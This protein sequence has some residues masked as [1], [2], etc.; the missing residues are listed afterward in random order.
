MAVIRNEGSGKG[1]GSPEAL[2]SSPMTT[3]EVVRRLLAMMG[4]SA[5]LLVFSFVAS[6]A[7]VVLQLWVPIIIGGAIDRMVAAGHVDFAGLSPYLLRL[8]VVVP[9][10]AATQ[11]WG[12]Y[13][14][15]RLSYETTNRMRTAAFD[16]L[17]R[18]PLSFVD[19]HAHGDILMRITG[20]VDQVGDGLLQGFGQLST[21][22]V[23]I[24]G[25]LVFMCSLSLPVAAVVVALTPLTIFVAGQVARRSS[26]SFAEQQRLQ[27]QLGAYVNETVS[28]QRLLQ[29]F[30]RGD[31]C[32]AEFA[33][34]NE[35][36]FAVG[37][38]AQ[39]VSSLTNPS[40]RVVNNVIYAA[41]AVVGCMCVVLG[42]PSPLT[43]G[44]VQSFLSYS[45]QYMKPFN[46]ISGVVTQLQAALASARRVFSLLDAPEEAPNPEGAHTLENPAGDLVFENVSFSY[47][48][49]NPL[50]KDITFHAAP[51]QRIAL[52]GPTGCGKTTLINLLLRFYDLDGGRILIDGHDT[53][54]CTRE[55]LRSAFGMVLQD[56]W[57]FSGTIADNIRYS[58]PGA[59]DEQVEQAARR[60][61]AHKFIEQL[62]DGYQTMVGE[63]GGALSQGQRQLLCIARVMLADPAVLLLDEATSSIDTRTELQVQDAFDR[64]MEGR[65]SLVVAHRLSTVRNADQILVMQDGRISEHGTHE[66]LLAQGSFYAKLY[67]SQ[68]EGLS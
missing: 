41:V 38:R 37:E 22:V 16:K 25:T 13:L 48:E 52:V 5:T 53:A 26:S 27:G 19:G 15:N 51:G 10:A 29:T 18:L 1:P 63:G 30:S 64:M 40:T 44:Q 9:L 58:R 35:Q 65:T 57:L 32:Q 12:G 39:F 66:E 23:T 59:T 67:E 24:V 11:F 33:R 55:S 47:V 68:W 42:R 31:Y 43:V 28:N 50:L 56:T 60:A 14:T 2:D 4:S 61:H 54:D 36:L 8:C 7:S 62:P 17:R 49:G 46:E 34:L 6:A 3:G 20:D 21:G 45:N